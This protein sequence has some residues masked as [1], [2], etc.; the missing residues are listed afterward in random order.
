MERKTKGTALRPSKPDAR[1]VTVADDDTSASAIGLAGVKAGVAGA[2]C[3]ALLML[4]NLVDIPLLLCLVLPGFLMVMFVAGMLAGLLAGDRL[5][6][7]TQATQ[8]GITAGFVSG[9]GA[10]F[11]AVVLSA[12]GLMFTQ[13]GEGVRAQFSPLQM[14]NLA[15]MGISP[16]AV[17]TTG[18]VLL[19]LLIWGAGG[20]VVAIILGIVG[21][22]VYCRLR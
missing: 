13:M 21:A 11:T 2:I 4:I 12:L 18:A 16:S 3:L 1:Q 15:D 20:T 5:K 7:P 10:G 14:K 17:E 22:R 8:A 9:L 6:T 19:A